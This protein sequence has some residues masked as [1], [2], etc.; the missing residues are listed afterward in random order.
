MDFIVVIYFIGSV[1]SIAL[2]PT[3]IAVQDKDRCESLVADLNKSSAINAS[4]YVNTRTNQLTI[5]K[6]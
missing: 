2:P 6:K 3:V 4:C 5:I 1:S